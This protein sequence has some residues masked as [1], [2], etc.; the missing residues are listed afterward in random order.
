MAQFFDFIKSIGLI[1]SNL[2]TMIISLTSTL[3]A[4][5]TEFLLF[6]NIIPGPAQWFVVLCLAV[7][8]VFIIID[9]L[10]DLF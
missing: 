4:G 5:G 10:R 8:V 3:I 9:I 7:P 1:I 2:I 6:Q